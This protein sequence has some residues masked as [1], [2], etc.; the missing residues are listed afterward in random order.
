MDGFKG[1]YKKRVDIPVNS[2]LKVMSLSG[3]NLLSYFSK[4]WKEYNLSAPNTLQY[5]DFFF[6]TVKSLKQNISTTI[7]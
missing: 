7:F 3:Y 2:V 4:R 6:K 5:L 1:F